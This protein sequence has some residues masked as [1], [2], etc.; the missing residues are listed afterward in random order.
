MDE[1]LVIESN[2]KCENVYSE[3]N[4]L[5]R[6]ILDIRNK[7]RTKTGYAYPY[8]I[9]MDFE[10]LKLVLLNILYE[11]T[12]IRKMLNEHKYYLDSKGLDNA[13]VGLDSNSRSPLLYEKFLSNLNTFFDIEERSFSF[14]FP[15]NLTLDVKDDE[16]YL[17]KIL[18]HFQVKKIEIKDLKKILAKIH[19]ESDGKE[20]SE[21]E[22]N[23]LE[24]QLQVLH[25][26]D[27]FGKEDV[28]DYLK[29]IP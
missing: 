5:I 12:N 17:N 15:L 21:G 14:M 10:G 25:N 16:K 19:S 1:K 3:L 22:L 23:Y 28:S 20:N 26:G 27:E 13:F 29:D 2:F 4:K 9:L 24:T 8:N 7:A 6:R 18:E 11:K